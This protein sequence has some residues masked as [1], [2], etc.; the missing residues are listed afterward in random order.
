MPCRAPAPLQ[1]DRGHLR[2]RHIEPNTQNADRGATAPARRSRVAPPPSLSPRSERSPAGVLPEWELTHITC[3]AQ[4]LAVSILSPGQGLRTRAKRTTGKQGLRYTRSISVRLH[5]CA[6][7]VLGTIETHGSVFI[8]VRGILGVH[9]CYSCCHKMDGET[10][11]DLLL[12]AARG[13]T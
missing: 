5:V 10:L 3:H 12:R 6:S 1:L 11:Q 8:G 2:I 7:P 13:V 4:G 9:L